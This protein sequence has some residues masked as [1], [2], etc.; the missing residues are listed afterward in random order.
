[1]AKEVFLLSKVESLGNE[2]DVV[3]VA[4]GYAR[5]YL[6]PRGL[7]AEANDAARRRLTKLQEQRSAAAAGAL[8]KARALAEKISSLSVTIA[9]KTREDDKLYGSVGAAEIA[10]ALEDQ[11]IEVD[12]HAL[13]M[14]TPLKELGVFDVKIKLH[15]EV[16]GSV[17]AWIVDADA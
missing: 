15:P 2:G 7:A 16:E 9:V 5:N 14:E 11:G 1:M 8:K 17:K 4:D 12:R 10:T 13:Q 3:S 6:L